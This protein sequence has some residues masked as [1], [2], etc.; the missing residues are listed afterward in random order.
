MFWLFFSIGRPLSLSI[1]PLGRSASYLW[2][3]VA[4]CAREAEPRLLVA[5]HLD[6]QPEVSQLHRRPLQLARQ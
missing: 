6:R 1:F 3:E 5:L 4:W 2:A